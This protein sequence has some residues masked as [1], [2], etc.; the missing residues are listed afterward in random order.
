M[1]AQMSQ[2]K[3][4]KIIVITGGTGFI[5]SALTVALLSRGYRVRILT[6][7]RDFYEKKKL[8][9]VEYFSWNSLKDPAPQ[10]ALEGAFAVVHLAGESVT[11][12]R[13]TESQKKILVESRIQSTRNLLRGI[14]STS[15][16]PE[17]LVGTS[18]IGFYGDR[19]SEDLSENSKP[20]VGFLPELCA[21]WERETLMAS[22][23]LRTSVVRVGIVL[24]TEAGALA[25]M[26]K[27]FRSGL[28]GVIGS[29]QHLMSWIHLNDLVRLYIFAM[30]NQTVSGVLN[31]VSSS[32]V[33][34]REFAQTLARC[35]DRPAIVPTP[36][37]VIRL[38]LGEMATIVLSSQKIFPKK[39][40]DLG[41][42]FE[43]S[44]L[45]SALN[46]LVA[47]MG[48]RG[49][50]TLR[51]YQWMPVSREKVFE[52]FSQASNLEILTPPW[53]HFRIIGM[54]DDH[55]KKG[56]LIDYK[57]RVRGVPIRWKTLIEEWNQGISFVDRMLRG[58]YRDWH[59]THTFEDL[60]GGTLMCDRVY[61]RL[62]VG[63]MG[64][65]VAL[66]WVVRDV[67]SIFE[68]RKQKITEWCQGAG[69][70]AQRR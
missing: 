38:L 69:V 4:K 34:Q 68:Y 48:F 19:G 30:E 8:L 26:L 52:F 62:P 5:G 70:N 1:K 23:V 36:R 15:H 11:A 14:N 43:F 3:Q 42:R 58:P 21:E 27:P 13:W 10:E 2:Q 61:Y 9:P 55:I 46:D 56:T 32:P 57:L 37:W 20:G 7:N 29:G 67:K 63:I 31:G 59:H 65:L 60:D 50:Y 45:Q 49:T 53:L 40:L 54:S 47:P 17:V 51:T 41:F 12:G 28:G 64:N 66:L 18:A 39:V 33:T 44:D 16:K 35:V 25:E 6:R 24:G 22:S